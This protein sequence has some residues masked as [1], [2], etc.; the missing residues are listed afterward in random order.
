VGPYRVPVVYLTSA[1]LW[2]FS[3]LLFRRISKLR[4]INC[5]EGFDPHRPYQ[6]IAS[7]TLGPERFRRGPFCCP[8]ATCSEERN[9]S[10][11]LF[12]A[13]FLMQVV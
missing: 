10:E 11:S 5:H 8:K 12:Q 9:K 13:K 4:G 7:K 3:V 6:Q 2:F 1:F